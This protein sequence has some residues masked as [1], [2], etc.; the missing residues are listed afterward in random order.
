VS[1]AA[2]GEIWLVD[3]GE[4]MGHEQGY[5]RPA[6]VVSSNRMN[7]SRAGLV[8]VVPITSRKR[9]LPSHV[10]IDAD[11]TTGLRDVSY[12]KVEDIKS[13]AT[14]RLVRRIGHVS[15]E[16]LLKLER[17]ITLVLEL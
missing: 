2:R 15:P 3:F 4:P 11:N 16:A 12:A 17:V 8:I 13:V 9:G 7:A 14:E 5:R 1:H 10:E 6:V